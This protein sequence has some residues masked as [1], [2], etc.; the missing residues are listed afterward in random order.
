MK[1]VDVRLKAVFLTLGLVIT[2]VIIVKFWPD[3]F[4]QQQ[5]DV[6][7]ISLEPKTASLFNNA[8]NDLRKRRYRQAI[9]G[10]RELLKTA[11][12]MPE[13]Y[14]NIGF[15]NLELKQYEQAKQAFNAA[16]DLRSGQV[17]AYWGL[18]VSLEGLCDI[19]TAIGAMKTYTHLAKQDDPYL[20]KANAALW[21][22]DHLKKAAE[23][24]GKNKIVCPN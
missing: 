1:G 11:P 19:P 20:N 16:L 2:I 8:L 7:N 9:E 5:A 18:A 17:N 24:G 21:E 14:V 22:W 13:A 6:A 4:N 3:A 10:F 12:T 15:A 23:Q